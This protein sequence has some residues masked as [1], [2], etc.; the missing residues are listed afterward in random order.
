MPP[1]SH[2]PFTENL[3]AEDVQRLSERSPHLFRQ[4]GDIYSY[5]R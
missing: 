1:P 4:D 5:D 3:D 2:V